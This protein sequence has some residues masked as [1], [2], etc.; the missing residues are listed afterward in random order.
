VAASGSGRLVTAGRVGRPHTLDGSFKVLDPVHPLAKGT[1]VTVAGVARTVRLRRGSDDQP[2]VALK[3]VTTKEAAA[4][5]G[6]ELMLVDERD[7]PI[8]EDEWL[9]D[10]LIGC[11]VP[12]LG[13]VER[14]I[15]GPS[16]DVLELA[17]GT[18]VPLVRDAIVSVD[19]EGRTVAVNRGFL[20]LSEEEG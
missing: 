18:L 14:I 20:G 8:E 7:W 5:L 9:A 10:D 16:C 4:A 3:G 19:V 6:G 12:G 13:R 17:G 15:A 2:I 1:R 11:E